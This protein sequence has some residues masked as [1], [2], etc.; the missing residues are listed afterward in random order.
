MPANQPSSVLHFAAAAA[1]GSISVQVRQV[2]ERCCAPGAVEPRRR[3]RILDPGVIR[4]R[5]IRHLVLN[6]LDAERVGAVHELAKLVK[7]PEV[8][9]D[10]VEIDRAVAVVIRDCLTVV[11]LA[12]VQMVDVVVNRREPDGGH[13]EIFQIGKVLDDPAEIAAVVI[14][15]LR[16]IVHAARDGWVIVGRVAVGEAIGHQEIDDVIGREALEAAGG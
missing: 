8:L 1:C 14:A 13:P 16:A 3:G 5:V 9:L 7:R 4:A 2:L 10:A 6:H 11:L 12:L 15:R